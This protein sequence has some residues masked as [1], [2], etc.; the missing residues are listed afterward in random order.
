MDVR[1]LIT[2]A[3]KEV[4]QLR[5][6]QRSLRMFILAPVIQLAMFGYAISTDLKGVTLGVVTEDPSPEA[7]RLVQAVME[8]NAFV[9]AKSSAQPA[10]A[11]RWMQRGEAQIVLL[12]PPRFGRSFDTGQ[13]P[14]IQVLSDGS[15]SNTAT[16]AAQY[17]SGAA[18]TWANRERLKRMRRHPEASVRF[19]RV[20][21]L[22]VEPRFWFNPS[23]KS[24]NYQVPGVLA[25]IVL[26]LTLTQTSLMVVKERDLGTL[27]QLSVTPIRASELLVGKTLPVAAL[28]LVMTAAITLVA[29]GWFRVP[30]RGSVPF[31]FFAATLYLL[32]TMGLGLLV[33]VISRSQMQAQ[34][35]ANF[36]STPLIMLSGFL[37]P[38]ANMPQWAQWLTLIMPT[39]YYMEVV[40]GVFLKGQGF[41]EL[42]PQAAALAVIGTTL[43]SG[44]ILLFRKRVD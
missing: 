30:L 15:D 5:R 25:L 26:V 37:F 40:R 20:P 9:L 35:T 36:L 7:R 28:G 16:L 42:W 6:D 3:R 11:V 34:L 41:A 38:I 44:G 33:S 13:T 24:R 27:E 23:L 8:T 31:L 18:S 14:S 22:G 4:Q 12:I 2:I 21:Q 32:S 17:L 1:R 19:V 10:D 29:W 39:R 43:Y